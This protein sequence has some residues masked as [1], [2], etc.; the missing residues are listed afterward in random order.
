[1]DLREFGSG[2]GE[3]IFLYAAPE[4]FEL[5]GKELCVEFDGGERTTLIFSADESES[6]SGKQHCTK[7]GDAIWLVAQVRLGIFIAYVLDLG[8]GLA[9]RATRSTDGGFEMSFGALDGATGQR[10]AY[11]DDL[12]GNTVEWTLGMHES[13]VIRMSYKD[14]SIELTRPYSPD[15]PTPSISSFRVVKITDTIYLKTAAIMY[16]NEEKF[17][18]L[19]CDFHRVLCV[20]SVFDTKGNVR[21]I[22]GHG[23]YPRDAQQMVLHKLSPFNN[24]SI[25]QYMPP[26]CFELEGETL[27]LIMDDGYNFTLRFLGRDTLEWNIA[28]QAPAK[29]EYKCHKADDTT[30]LITYELADVL[31]RASHM[32]VIDLENKLVTRIIASI[33]KNPRW[34]YLMATEFEFGAIAGSGEINLYPRHGFTSDMTGNIA[35]WAYGS[36]MSTVHIYHSSSSYRLTHPRDRV[37]T[38]EEVR[39]NYAFNDMQDSLPSTDEPT[40]YVKIKEGMYLISLTEINA[41]KLLGAKIG[42]RSNTLCFLQNYKR[43]RVIGRAFGTS[44]R[45]DGTDVQ[46]HITIGAFGRVIEAADEE[47]KELLIAQNPYIV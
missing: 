43:G 14:N 6:S 24:H 38:R 47:L 11:T 4:S 33:G 1:M 28:E 18:C 9:T 15:L 37:G 21:M 45:P 12:E 35:Q 7:I 29:A 2:T 10:H 3:D 16:D 31:P 27:E 40:V 32:F 44:T 26:H 19:L 23:G 5:R 39:E 17:V 41:E 34:P 8:T 13:S 46:T 25:T 20:G 42:F 22:G 36:E 30:Y